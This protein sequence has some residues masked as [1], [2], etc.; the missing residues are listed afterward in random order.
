M[1]G[2]LLLC[3]NSEEYILLYICYISLWY[4]YIYGEGSEH[5]VGPPAQL[6]G[7]L[8]Q[9]LLGS[10]QLRLQVLPRGVELALQQLQLV[11]CVGKSLP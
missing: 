9:L 4:W 7:E 1:V 10:A 3:Y 2:I 8:V 6:V 11:S 5:F